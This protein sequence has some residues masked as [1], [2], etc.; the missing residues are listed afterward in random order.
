MRWHSGEVVSQEI[1]RARAAVVERIE[2]ARNVVRGAPGNP[3]V[4]LTVSISG[5]PPRRI[6]FVLFASVSPRA[7]ENYHMNRFFSR[8]KNHDFQKH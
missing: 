6:D 3:R 4:W 7:A 8:A 1:L 2:A 5:A